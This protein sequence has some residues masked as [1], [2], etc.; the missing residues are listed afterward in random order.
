MNAPGQTSLLV[1]RIRMPAPT[2]TLLALVCFVQFTSAE[3]PAGNA[4]EPEILAYE[5]S[6]KDAH[7]PEGAILFTGASSIRMW[8]S[9]AKDF[10]G[11]TVIN[12][13]FGGSQLSDSIYFADRISIHYKPQTIII[14]AGGND[15]NAGKSPEQVLTDFKTYVAKVRA[16]LQ[17]VKI[18][19]LSLN[20]S[21]QRWEQRDK[22]QQANKLVR[23][24][25]A[26]GKSLTYV[27]LWSDSIGPD[28][29]PKPELYVDDKLHPSTSGYSLRTRLLLPPHQAPA[30]SFALSSPS[31]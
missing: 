1:L 28:G 11:L 2:L 21:P 15:I 27:D 12:R 9:L 5:K 10:P 25:I 26:T 31:I 17:D 30:A 18:I 8:T 19:F 4:F 3:P 13:G 7:P 23:E 14:Q 22:Q 16:A 20:P 29:M 6:D 24:Y